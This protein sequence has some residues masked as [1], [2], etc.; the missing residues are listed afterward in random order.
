MH[1]LLYD[2]SCMTTKIKSL[3]RLTGLTQ[4]TFGDNFNQG[5]AGVLP[6]GFNQRVVAGV[7]PAGLTQL[8]FGYRFNQRMAVGALPASLDR[9]SVV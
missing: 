5:A 6:A 8:T 9:K 1:H 4:L 3:P 7:L 2:T